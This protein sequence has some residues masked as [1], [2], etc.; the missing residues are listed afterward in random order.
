MEIE[1]LKRAAEFLGLEIDERFAGVINRG[2]FKRYTDE[3]F[4]PHE[5]TGRHWLVE[6]MRKLIGWGSKWNAFQY[7]IL[8]EYNK[9]PNPFRKHLSFPHWLVTAPSELCFEKI[10]EV[11]N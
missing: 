3:Q 8:K 9:E 2:L 6:M 10:M 4:N 5:E 11:I 7:E 1:K